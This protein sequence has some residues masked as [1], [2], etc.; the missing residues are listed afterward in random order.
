M[1]NMLPHKNLSLVLKPCSTKGAFHWT[2]RVILFSLVLH[3]GGFCLCAF[4]HILDITAILSLWKKMS[5]WSYSLW[6]A[7]LL[8]H[9]PVNDLAVQYMLEGK[10]MF[11]FHDELYK[12]LPWLRSSVPRT[13]REFE[14]C[15]QSWWGQGKRGW[16]DHNNRT[17]A[18]ETGAF[19]YCLY[20]SH[21][22]LQGYPYHQTLTN[23]DP[24]PV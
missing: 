22:G 6:L 15:S 18:G 1:L 13:H 20:S 17:A 5:S 19:L 7:T 4:W 2:L 3:W 21:W 10:Q 16:C 9:Y 11:C 14:K 24:L 23:C 12:I 8:T